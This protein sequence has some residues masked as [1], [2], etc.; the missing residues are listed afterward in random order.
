MPI[1][2]RCCSCDTK[3]RIGSRKAGT[4]VHCPRCGVVLIVPQ[5]FRDNASDHEI[6]AAPPE[7]QPLDLIQAKSG[8]VGE[9]MS[10]KNSISF[11][12][13]GVLKNSNNLQR[14]DRAEEFE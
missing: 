9:E 11:V 3:L 13:T 10:E 5:P 12:V 6:E 2:F 4:K 7:V 14:P 8:R 1:H